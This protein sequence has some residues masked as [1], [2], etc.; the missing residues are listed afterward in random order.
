MSISAR[1]VIKQSTGFRPPV[2]HRPLQMLIILLVLTGLLWV[3]SKP[4][5]ANCLDEDIPISV[6]DGISPAL[7]LEDDQHNPAIIALA[8]KELWLVAW[9][10][11]RNWGTTGVDIYGRFIDKN[12]TYYGDEIAICIQPGNQTV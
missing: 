7:T 3:N 1:K 6:V 12:G 9:E 5:Q 2:S 10:D 8:D 11:W 4:A